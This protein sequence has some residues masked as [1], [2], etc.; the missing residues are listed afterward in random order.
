MI[1]VNTAITS[2]DKVLI[3]RKARRISSSVREAF[4]TYQGRQDAKSTYLD[5]LLKNPYRV[6][7]F[8]IFLDSIS[9]LL[10]SDILDERT[11]LERGYF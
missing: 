6:E 11:V 3:L 1:P 2:I 5:F 7:V 4:S 10:R 9:Q 8:Q